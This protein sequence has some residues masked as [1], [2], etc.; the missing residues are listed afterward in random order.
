[1]GV[2]GRAWSRGAFAFGGL[3]MAATMLMGGGL[4]RG[5]IA[6]FEETRSIDGVPYMRYQA[7]VG[8]ALCTP[9]F[10]LDDELWL[11]SCAPIRATAI[12][13]DVMAVGDA[14][15]IEARPITGLDP[16]QVLAVTGSNCGPHA[17]GLATNVGDGDDFATSQHATEIASCHAAI[18]IAPPDRC[19]IVW[20]PPAPTP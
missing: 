14:E 3:A 16:S 15:V 7:C 19:E 20:G 11:V 12:G 18:A 6:E 9:T 8:N 4:A 17:W 10:E 1:M 13:F 5:Q 2:A